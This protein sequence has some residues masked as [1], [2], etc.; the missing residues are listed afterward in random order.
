MYEWFFKFLN[1]LVL[2]YE[3]YCGNLEFGIILV[4]DV[5]VI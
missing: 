5:V 1:V 3:G 4:F 2:L